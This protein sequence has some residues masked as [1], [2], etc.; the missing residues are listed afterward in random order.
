MNIIDK[1]MQAD[2]GK[3]ELPTKEYEIKRLSKL[4]GFP[5]VLKLQAIDPERYTE[6]QENSI[7][8]KKSEINKVKMYNMHMKTILAGVVEPSLKDDGLRKHF[9][10]TTPK[11][12]VNKLFLSGEI[13]NIS[14]EIS[15]LCGYDGQEEIDE[16][17][18]N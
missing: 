1:L 7:E 15:K 16:K 8:M 13:A 11:E 9:G 17:I 14:E 18:K 3:L 2:A 4:F 5:F 6:I 10:V 12:L